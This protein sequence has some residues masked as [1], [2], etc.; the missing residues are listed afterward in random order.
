MLACGA[1]PR[2]PSEDEGSV[3]EVE[4]V[5]NDKDTTPIQQSRLTMLVLLQA[6]LFVLLVIS[7]E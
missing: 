7:M 6:I 2:F 4:E 3:D 5:F 1:D